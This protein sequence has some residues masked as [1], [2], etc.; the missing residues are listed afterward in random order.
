MF[1]VATPRQCHP[2]FSGQ[3]FSCKPVRLHL[4]LAA[5]DQVKINKQDSRHTALQLPG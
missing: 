2:I 1:K 4:T 3:V 5:G